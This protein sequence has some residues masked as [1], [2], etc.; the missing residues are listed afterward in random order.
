MRHSHPFNAFELTGKK[1]GQLK[2]FKENVDHYFCN[3]YFYFFLCVIEIN[4]T[5]ELNISK[6][7]L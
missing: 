5:V 3:T 7:F 1:W 4:I 2:A 6:P